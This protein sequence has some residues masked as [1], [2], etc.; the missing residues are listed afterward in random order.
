MPGPIKK[1]P[2][3]FYR[4]KA[5][6]EPVL[7]W[8]RSLDQEDRRA[9]GNALAVVEFGWPVGM[10]VCR[11]LEGEKRLWE[12]RTSITNGRIARL[13][14]AIVRG[15]MVILHGFVKKTRKTPDKDKALARQR[16][17]DVERHEEELVE[18]PRRHLC[19]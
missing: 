10:P 2:A 11:A 6:K 5:G 15:R 16:F 9:I 7:E 8:L 17:K 3:F 4:T 19:R 18:P 1:L 14:F 13:V 12:V